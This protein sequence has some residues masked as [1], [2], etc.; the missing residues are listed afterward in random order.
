VLAQDLNATK[1]TEHK[2]IDPNAFRSG[3]ISRSIGAWVLVASI[4]AFAVAGNIRLRHLVVP[5]P[6]CIGY[7]LPVVFA[8]E[9][10]NTGLTEH[11]GVDANAFHGGGISHGFDKWM[12]LVPLLGFVVRNLKIRHFIGVTG[13]FVASLGSLLPIVLAQVTNTS[14]I[15]EHKGNGPVISSAVTVAN[16]VPWAFVALLLSLFLLGHIKPGVFLTRPYVSHGVAAQNF[17]KK[18]DSADASATS[19]STSTLIAVALFVTWGAI[20]GLLFIQIKNFT[21]VV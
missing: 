1:L 13:V 16:L 12:L 14:A 11:K 4:P 6:A 7:L 18:Q 9:T 20:W 8:Q 2:G 10:N 15:T 17:E 3:S 19:I 21:G 5:F